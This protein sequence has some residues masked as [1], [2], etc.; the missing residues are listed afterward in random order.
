MTKFKLKHLCQSLIFNKVSLSKKGSNTGVFLYLFIKKE[1]LTQVF[2]CKFCEIFT[3]TFFK[4]HLLFL[5]LNVCIFIMLCITLCCVA[6]GF[7]KKTYFYFHFYISSLNAHQINYSN[8]IT[9]FLSCLRI[10]AKIR[11]WYS[12]ESKRIH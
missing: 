5:R 3:N 6:G 4:K 7:F 1:A 9:D 8:V 12:S 10:A 2:F 11:F